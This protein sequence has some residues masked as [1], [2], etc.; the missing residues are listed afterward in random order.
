MSLIY[1]SLYIFH[2]LV[3]VSVAQLSFWEMLGTNWCL[4]VKRQNVHS[5]L[6]KYYEKL[7]LPVILMTSTRVKKGNNGSFL[8]AGAY[9]NRCAMYKW[10]RSL[11]FIASIERRLTWTWT[12]ENSVQKLRA[13]HNKTQC[14][15]CKRR[16]GLSIPL[17]LL[18]LVCSGKGFHL[19]MQS[20]GGSVFGHFRHDDKQT[21][22]PLFL[23]E[24]CGS[25]IQ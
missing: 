16:V 12:W 10:R 21:N 14:Q 25:L 3:H 20:L 9:Q 24:A 8:K 18:F 17:Q 2:L 1:I 5:I 13:N 22:S 6:T 23:V 15:L 11:P 19:W 7:G 4:K